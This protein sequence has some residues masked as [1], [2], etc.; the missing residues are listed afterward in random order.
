MVEINPSEK[1]RV[2][3]FDPL[4]VDPDPDA[5][6]EITPLPNGFDFHKRKDPVRR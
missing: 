1:L 6:P 3:A 2:V 4:V 5:L